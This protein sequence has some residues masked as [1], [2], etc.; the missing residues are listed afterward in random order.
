MK[1]LILITFSD[2]KDSWINPLWEEFIR[3]F[4][5]RIKARFGITENVEFVVNQVQLSEG[6]KPEKII[7]TLIR[8]SRTDVV[9]IIVESHSSIEINK[10]VYFMVEVLRGDIPI[11]MFFFE[12][13]TPKILREIVLNKMEGVDL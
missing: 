9:G 10:K 8:E 6:S 7:G 11:E 13:R 5:K 2:P 4:V 1:K 3:S 12:D